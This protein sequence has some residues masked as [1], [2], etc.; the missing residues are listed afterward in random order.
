MY[1]CSC[2]GRCRSGIH[3]ID[4]LRPSCVCSCDLPR[5][6]TGAVWRP[7]DS[8]G[9]DQANVRAIPA[10]S[11][12]SVGV[13]DDFA[14]FAAVP[15]SKDK[16]P[17]TDSSSIDGESPGESQNDR[18]VRKATVQ[19]CNIEHQDWKKV[20]RMH[21]CTFSRSGIPASRDC[22][23]LMYNNDLRLNPSRVSA[24]FGRQAGH[25]GIFVAFPPG[26]QRDAGFAQLGVQEWEPLP[27]RSHERFLGLKFPRG[28]SLWPIQPGQ[29]RT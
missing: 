12:D 7:L 20:Q 1:R 10:R 21:L 28:W 8:K 24:I 13:G 6:E 27:G 11:R 16:K 22:R 4:R 14:E 26:K 17:T 29:P 19:N 25:L 9:H 23:N 5:V 2:R 18:D 3:P 15:L